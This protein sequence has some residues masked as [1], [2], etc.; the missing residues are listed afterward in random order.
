M[1]KGILLDANNGLKIEKGTLRIGERKMQ[2][3]YLVLLTNQGEF[4]H[5]PLVGVNLNKMIRGRENREKILK[6]IE[7]GLERAGVKFDD[8]KAQ[9]GIL[10]NK[11]N[12]T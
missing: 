7:I 6:T 2:D 4:K 10:I 12:I 11:R 5:D 1:S 3:A 8:V 9:F